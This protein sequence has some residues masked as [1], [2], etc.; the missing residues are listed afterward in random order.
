MR[1]GLLR[2][3]ITIQNETVT[4]DATGAEVVTWG[5]F[6]TARAAIENL[7][8]SEAFASN[9]DQRLAQR[10]TKI[11][12]RARDGLT[13]KMR[14]LHGSAVYNIEQIIQDRTQAREINLIC[15]EIN[16]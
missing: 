8:G 3:V 14:V 13:T 11:T 7:S 16:V 15:E 2:H 4:R 10:M 12:I 5:A 1:A 6:L 9:I